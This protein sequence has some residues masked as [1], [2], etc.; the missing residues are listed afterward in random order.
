MDQ[1][2]VNHLQAPLRRT[3]KD[4]TLA[5][6]SGLWF[7]PTVLKR[8]HEVIQRVCVLQGGVA[9]GS[10]RSTLHPK[11]PERLGGT[12]GLHQSCPVGNRGPPRAS[13]TPNQPQL[14]TAIN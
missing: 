9:Q 13:G 7:P 3:V 14:Q 2:Q 10:L 6:V 4:I 1:T 8:P 11:V 12:S 5:T